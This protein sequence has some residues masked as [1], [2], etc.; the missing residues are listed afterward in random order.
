MLGQ[1][2]PSQVI[3]LTTIWLLLL[4]C[5]SSAILVPAIYVA[6]FAF[7]DNLSSRYYLYGERSLFGSFTMDK[8]TLTLGLGYLVGYP[9]ASASSK[10]HPHDLIDALFSEGCSS[11]TNI[12]IMLV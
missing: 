3:A 5:G 2:D 1:E 11:I 12:T 7:A 8:K 6:S 4:A 10:L 9:L